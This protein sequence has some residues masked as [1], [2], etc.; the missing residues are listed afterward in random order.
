MVSS[1]S[2][3]PQKC[4][5]PCGASRVRQNMLLFSVSDGCKRVLKVRDERDV[6]MWFLRQIARLI[7]EDSDGHQI[8]NDGQR[9][10]ICTVT[11]VDGDSL[12]V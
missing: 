1:V 10:Q 4:H 2:I 12:M 8:P 7:T 6:R 11:S 5:M 9:Q 3:D